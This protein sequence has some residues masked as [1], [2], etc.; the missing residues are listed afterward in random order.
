[1]CQADYDAWVA[2]RL[3]DHFY[4][5]KAWWTGL[6]VIG[7]SVFLDAHS[8]SRRP[9]GW[10][11]GNPFL[12]SNPSAGRIAGFATLDFSAQALLHV[13]AW[14]QSHF[15]PSKPWRG[16]GQWGVPAGAFATNGQRGIRNYY[17]GAR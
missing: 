2:P 4:K 13:F 16:I 11:E 10:S 9:R 17:L 14:K 8:T 3:D 12:G 7:L 1:M 6:G 15:D 5:E